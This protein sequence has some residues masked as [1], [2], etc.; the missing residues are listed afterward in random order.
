MPKNRSSFYGVFLRI[1]LAHSLT[2]AE[3]GTSPERATG[4]RGDN[5]G[6][7]GALLCRL[8]S[9]AV[10]MLQLALATGYPCS[11]NGMR[12]CGQSWRQLPAIRNVGFV[13]TYV[14]S[15]AR[16]ACGLSADARSL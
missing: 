2:S 4:T 7:A 6:R 16:H 8:F 12:A 5:S 14:T 13:R 9:T 3:P 1:I 10:A 11:L 15:C